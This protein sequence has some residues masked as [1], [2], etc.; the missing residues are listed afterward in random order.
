MLG[1]VRK[2]LGWWDVT[3]GAV[4]AVSAACPQPIA[5]IKDAEE[6]LGISAGSLSLLNVQFIN[7]LAP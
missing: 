5:A 4:C 3:L 1:H 7:Q 2:V 6:F